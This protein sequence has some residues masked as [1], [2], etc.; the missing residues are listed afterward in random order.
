MSNPP[1]RLRVALTVAVGAMVTTVA[2]ALTATSALAQPTAAPPPAAQQTVQ[3]LKYRGSVNLRAL[4]AQAAKT[5][6]ATT[7]RPARTD[8]ARPTLVK[9]AA[10]EPVPNPAPN[11]SLVADH[12]GLHGFVG[13]T[14]AEQAFANNGLEVEPPDQGLCAANGLLFE[15]VNLGVSVYR[16]SGAQVTPVVSL[17]SFFGLA[18]LYNGRTYGPFTS[19]PR[20][21]FD[22]QTRRWYVTVTEIDLD[23]YTGAFGNRSSI[24]MAVSATSDP[25]GSYGLF[26]LL[27]SDDGSSGTP[28]HPGCPCF[29]DYPQIGAD[30][31][32]FI[33]TTQE[34]SIPG[35]AY[36]GAQVYAVSK[37]LLAAAATLGLQGVPPAV[38]LQ[39]GQLNGGPSYRLAPAITPP[40]AKFPVNR[41]YFVSTAN[42][43]TYSARSMALW[44]LTG[45]GSLDSQ[46]PSL[47]LTHKLIPSRLY[48]DSGPAV[49][50]PG[51]R[52]LG[53]QLNKPMGL[54]EAEGA[55]VESP[56]SYVDGRVSAVIPTGF[57]TAVTPADRGIEWFV[58]N[59]ANGGS[60]ARQGY[61]RVANTA[62]MFPAIAVK[63]DGKGVVVMSAVGPNMFPSA[64]YSA[65]DVNK[66]MVGP[67]RVAKYGQAPE[68]GFTCYRPGGVCRW[69]DYSY[70]FATESN[71]AFATEF[72]G[73]SA[74][75]PDLNYSTFVGTVG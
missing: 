5:P 24:L 71:V 10:S 8:K 19:D 53:R 62:L 73:P 7:W 35:T 52:P 57:G 51:P 45:T 75:T 3:P 68:D 65:F 22:Q 9:P 47:T 41:E 32:A 48:T 36:N 1:R 15:Q 20:C 28:A 39:G 25:T 34:F 55:S 61:A 60:M 29:G 44:T 42:P 66:G 49:Q 54:I 33:V 40:G 17:A 12:S 63:A 56:V 16:T 26:E 72:V 43:L 37:R 11:R 27:T 14:A 4:A 58:I 38:H 70:A 21:H 13:I 59:P 50:K 2:P 31:T 30:G 23:P 74:R 6:P 18:P 69:G 46:N 64:V 67:I